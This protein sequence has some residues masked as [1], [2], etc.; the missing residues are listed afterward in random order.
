MTGPL[1]AADAARMSR[2]VAAGVLLLGLL[3][4]A[5]GGGGAGDDDDTVDAAGVAIDAPGAPDASPDARVIPVLRNPVSLPDDEL[6][7]QAAAILGEGGSKNCDRCHALTRDRLGSWQTQSASA[8]TRC[9]TN[10]APMTQ[11]EAAAIV[12]CFRD[13]PGVATSAWHASNLG[14]YATAATLPWF[15]YVFRTAFPATWEEQLGVFLDQASMPRS[16]SGA[17]TQPQFD[18][19]AEWFA[20]GLPA[21]ET[22]IPGDPPVTQ[23]TTAVTPDMQ[24][25][26]TEMQTQGWRAANAEA[27]ILMFGCAGATDPRQCLTAYPLS[28]A[29]SWSERWNATAPTTSLRVL[30]QYA[31][32]SNYWTRSSADGRYV[33]FGGA[34]A[35]SQTYRSTVVDLSGPTDMRAAA[36]YDPGFFPDNSGFALQGNGARFCEQSLLAT[37]PTTIT[38]DE[39]QCRVTGAVGLYQHLGAARGG[40]YWTVD[41][42][43]TNDNGGRSTSQPTRSDPSASFSDSASIDLVPLIHTGSQFVPQPKVTK[44]LPYEGD[45]VMSPT[46][47]LLVSRVRAS[48]SQT[49]LILRKV[50]ATPSGGSYD[51]DVPEIARYCVRGGKPGI[52]YDDRWMVIH[53]YVEAGDWAALGFGSASDPGFVEL[54]SAGSANIYLVDLLTGVSTRLTTMGPGQYALYPHFRSDGWIYFTVR[55]RPRGV[56]NIVASDAALVF[57]AP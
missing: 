57:E 26:V 54:A 3:S 19:V 10:V 42:Q 23:C 22:A 11:A 1:G 46:A 32:L 5:C 6:A 39:P 16:D 8:V 49:V 27:G 2:A 38:F 21:L 30:H 13:E 9:L 56:E 4:S 15:D 12:E 45:V 36:Y 37:S 24:S 7:L 47:K 20:R 28:T 29:E 50:V 35:S 53:H 17:L 18:I 34:A 51:V 48:A 52:S 44:A 41:G 31:Y 14:I 55:D 25:H 43:F 40:D 33:A